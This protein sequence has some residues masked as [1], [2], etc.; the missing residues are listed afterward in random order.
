MHRLHIMG[1][2]VY[3]ALLLYLQRKGSIKATYSIKTSSKSLCSSLVISVLALLSFSQLGARRQHF[4]SLLLTVGMNALLL[5]TF[6]LLPMFVKQF[7]LFSFAFTAAL[8]LASFWS[9]ICVA[10]LT[11]DTTGNWSVC[12]VIYI[13]ICFHCTYCVATYN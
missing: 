13:F 5:H 4:T 1:C 3:F 10:L 8:W 7:E 11:S 6:E 2:L 12:S 9:C